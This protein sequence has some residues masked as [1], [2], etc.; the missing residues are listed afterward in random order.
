MNFVTLYLWE[1]ESLLN[2]QL[3]TFAVCECLV[4]IIVWMLVCVLE[5]AMIHT[6]T[7]QVH[8]HVEI[9][10]LG[11]K[12]SGAHALFVPIVFALLPVLRI[13]LHRKLY[14]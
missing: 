2:G 4:W 9:P 13:C 10:V 8:V 7:T 12:A 6:C 5:T 1:Y 14:L 11:R 3:C